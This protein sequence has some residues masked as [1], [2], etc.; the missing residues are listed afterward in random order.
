MPNSNEK[1]PRRLAKPAEG[2]KGIPIHEICL[3]KHVPGKGLLILKDA[4]ESEIA[5]W[6]VQLLFSQQ[7]VSLTANYPN[8]WCA[9]V[10]DGEDGPRDAVAARRER[11][12]SRV[13]RSGW[14]PALRLRW[15]VAGMLL[16]ERTP[17]P[18]RIRSSGK[19]TERI[20]LEL[21]ATGLSDSDYVATL[22][23]LAI[24]YRHKQE[25]GL[26]ASVTQMVLDSTDDV[27]TQAAA[28]L[29]LGQLAEE[30]GLLQTAQEYYAG[31]LALSSRD[32][33]VTYFL[34]NNT[35]YCLN[36]L[37][38]HGEAEHYCRSAI[39][40]D[41]D[42]H[43]AFKNLGVS[44]ERLGDLPAAARAYMDATR[45]APHDPRALRLLEKLLADHPEVRFSI[46]R[47]SLAER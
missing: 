23:K 28:Y 33:A 16:T 38:R 10:T 14:M 2:Q 17:L 43:N 11:F 18:R 36:A 5:D 21:L 41:P 9:V 4:A 8:D 46:P 30:E 20:L 45:I 19:V 12:R 26:A 37:G 1:H 3:L 35:G 34:N 29:Q 25:R 32:K 42:R 6:E 13:N 47:T 31:G 22:E 15:P 44:L 40:I 27:E 39:E 7:A 24:F